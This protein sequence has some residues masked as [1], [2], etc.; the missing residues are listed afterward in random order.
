MIS[1]ILLLL[2]SVSVFNSQYEKCYL[3]TVCFGII[4]KAVLCDDKAMSVRSCFA[5]CLPS[6][7][8]VHVT[9]TLIQT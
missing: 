6:C 3:Y 4:Y 2:G 5:S 9:R 1:G 8:M 7:G